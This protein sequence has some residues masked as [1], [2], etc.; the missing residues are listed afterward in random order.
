[1]PDL[2]KNIDPK[3]KPAPEMSKKEAIKKQ[4][5]SLE[6][7]AKQEHIVAQGETLSHIALKY[8]GKATP[9]YYT[10]IYNH[11]RE[12]IG[13]N[14]DIIIPGQKLVIPELPEELK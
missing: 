8:Y 2:M 1:M 10:L 13:D 14:I 11:N 6:K 9:P 4:F 12:V 3:P 7:A 5:E